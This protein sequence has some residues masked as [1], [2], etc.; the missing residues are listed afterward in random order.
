MGTI[1]SGRCLEST[2]AHLRRD[3]RGR[4]GRAGADHHSLR[5]A[6]RARR[7]DERAAVARLDQPHPAA[8][9]TQRKLLCTPVA[10]RR[11]FGNFRMR[12]L[13]NAEAAVHTC[14]SAR[15][16]DRAR[17]CVPLLASHGTF[18][19]APVRARVPEVVAICGRLWELPKTV[20]S[21]NCHWTVFGSAASWWSWS[22][23]RATAKATAVRT[24]LL[25]VGLRDL[26]RELHELVPRVDRHR[27]E[28]AI[29]RSPRTCDVGQ[30]LI[31]LGRVHG[32]VRARSCNVK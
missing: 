6:R 20:K 28:V 10:P 16:A 9:A 27:I 23:G 11:R 1:V 18:A 2:G 15:P 31:S 32:R 17:M 5:A 14:G 8:T 22:C 25:E 7:V 21:E 29:Q 13:P 24:P 3:S 30:A 26:L 12:K 19:Q 4:G